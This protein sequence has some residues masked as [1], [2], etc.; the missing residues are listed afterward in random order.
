MS[1]E[2][3]EPLEMLKMFPMAEALL[4]DLGGTRLCLRKA[5]QWCLWGREERAE[6]ILRTLDQIDEAGDLVFNMCHV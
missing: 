2:R 5:V 4:Q 3:E 1:P 6:P